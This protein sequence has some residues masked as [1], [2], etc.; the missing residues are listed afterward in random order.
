MKTVSQ[1]V[2][3]DTIQIVHQGGA[4]FDPLILKSVVDTLGSSSATSKGEQTGPDV[5]TP[6][7]REIL[8]LIGE[9]K[10]NSQIAQELHYAVG[11][12]KNMI[13]DIFLKLQVTDRAQAVLK[14]I[15]L[16]ILR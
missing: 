4:A 7:E 14:G 16:G 3:I 15:R 9:G 13:Q 6:K 8:R 1:R 11:S 12:I 2:L 10:T 5:L